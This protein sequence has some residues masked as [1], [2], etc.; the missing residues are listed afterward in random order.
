[1][2]NE[3]DPAPPGLQGE[4]GGDNGLESR[5]ALANERTF[6]AWQRTAL[7]LLAAAVA[8]VRFVPPVLV[9]GAPRVAAAV[10]AALAVLSGANGVRRWERVDA[11]IRAGLPL[12]VQRMPTLLGV[13]LVLV[14]AVGV[15]LVLGA[16]APR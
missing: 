1:M 11:A 14:A 13:G 12:P 6:L 15:L 3:A 5:F 4:A 16:A 8:V 9:P 2:A 7:G 10:L